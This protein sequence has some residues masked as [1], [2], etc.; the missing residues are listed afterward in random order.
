MVSTIV[1]ISESVVGIGRRSDDKS[2]KGKKAVFSFADSGGSSYITPTN[3]QALNPISSGKGIPI[4]GVDVNV[5]L[6]FDI[7]TT[8]QEP[9]GTYQGTLTI[10]AMAGP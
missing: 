4:R 6:R 5:Q 1:V 8:I 10:T 7:K 2:R 9:A 3:L